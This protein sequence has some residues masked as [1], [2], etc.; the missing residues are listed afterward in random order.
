[1]LIFLVRTRFEIANESQRQTQLERAG[2]RHFRKDFNISSFDRNATP[3]EPDNESARR[4]RFGGIC[5][6]ISM[7]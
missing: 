7:S 1:P 4:A 5:P 3:V 6:V 2:T